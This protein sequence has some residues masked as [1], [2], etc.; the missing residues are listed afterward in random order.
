[1]QSG[2]NSLRRGPPLWPQG[3]PLPSLSGAPETS[4]SAASQVRDPIPPSCAV[5]GRPANRS[6]LGRLGGGDDAPLLR[7]V[8][9]SSFFREAPSISSIAVGYKRGSSSSSCSSNSGAWDLSL[10]CGGTLSSLDTSLFQAGA[11]QQQQQQQQ[12]KQQQPQDASPPTFALHCEEDE[13]PTE[14]EHCVAPRETTP[15]GHASRLEYPARSPSET[16]AAAAAAAEAAAAAAA[17]V[18]RGG[19]FSPEVSS[20][21]SNKMD[22]AFRRSNRGDDDPLCSTESSSTLVS[23]RCCSSPNCNTRSS[24][25]TAAALHLPFKP[26]DAAATTAVT[27][28]G[29]LEDREDEF[30]LTELEADPPKTKCLNTQPEARFASSAKDSS[31]SRETSRCEMSIPGTE[32][33]GLSHHGEGACS[34]KQCSNCCGCCRKR[35]A[36]CCCS[37]SRNCDTR[38]DCRTDKGTSSNRTEGSSSCCCCTKRDTGSCSRHS[39]ASNTQGNGKAD[40]N[41]TMR[42]D[43]TSS[44]QHVPLP[45]EP[46]IDSAESDPESWCLKEPAGLPKGPYIRPL[47]DYASTTEP[48]TSPAS[49]LQEETSSHGAPSSLTP[50][51]SSLRFSDPEAPTAKAANPKPLKR[52]ASDSPTGADESLQALAAFA[53]RVRKQLG[54][55]TDSDTDGS[56]TESDQGVRLQT[57]T[58]DLELMGGAAE[59]LCR[60][61]AKALKLAPPPKFS[62]PEDGEARLHQ[63]SKSILP[64]AQTRSLGE[65]P[66]GPL[67]AFAEGDR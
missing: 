16:A 3:G 39:S 59:A 44:S 9:H 11:S 13:A 64:Q 24:T 61:L 27:H 6:F 10:A 20:S 40:G 43:R 12:Q 38:R 57:V 67:K 56:A 46:G 32:C 31:S 26:A 54:R 35:D 37:Y 66:R 1:M 7:G 14:R 49:L 47:D 34:E 53:R 41:S 23:S 21:C 58:E 4:H 60:L 2:G 42:G 50:K 62:C 65:A 30:S 19:A 8:G 48:E 45:G 5:C 51:L 22:E 29:K 18:V 33:T 55:L 28:R 17:A 52:T 15:P 25:N 63:L 36:C